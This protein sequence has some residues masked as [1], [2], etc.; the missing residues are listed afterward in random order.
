MKLFKG[1]YKG[2]ELV[3]IGGAIILASIGYDAAP[4]LRGFGVMIVAFGAFRLTQ[5]EKY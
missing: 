1:I 4:L 3:V 5:L 2:T